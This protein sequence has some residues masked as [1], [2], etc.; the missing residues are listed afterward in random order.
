M[1]HIAPTT[2]I[3]AANEFLSLAGED[4]RNI[5]Q[6]KLQKL[7]F[8]GHAW[9]LA[10]R[11]DQPLFDQ[12]F[13]AWPW[14]PVVRDVYNQTR[15]Y[16]RGPVTTKLKELRKTGS[17]ATDFD[18][19]TPRGVDSEEVKTFLRSIWESLK[20]YSG[21]Q[22]S[23]ATHAPGEP[24]TII[25]ERFGSLDGKPTIPNTLISDIFK[26]KLANVA[27]NPAAG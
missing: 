22:L 5:D 10:L 14:G 27:A 21:I 25:K 1:P 13:E 26:K 8:Y 15:Q 19:V 24:W 4:G 23:N 9:H 2:A 12:D 6:M 18:F 20:N 11:D 3:A 16:G 7:L 17:N